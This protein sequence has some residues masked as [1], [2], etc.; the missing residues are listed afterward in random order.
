MIEEVRGNLFDCGAAA[1]V[2]PCSLD[3]I[4]GSGLSLHFRKRFPEMYWAHRAWQ[5]PG[6]PAGF[7]QEGD[8]HVWRAAQTSRHQPVVLSIPVRHTHDGEPDLNLLHLGLRTLG[9][10]LQKQELR[11]PSIAIPRLGSGSL[12]PLPWSQV[13]PLILQTVGDLPGR[14]LLWVDWPPTRKARSV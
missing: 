2:N 14:R 1:L 4:M 7:R 6:N 12:K 10:L 13:R 8:I 5:D 3:G 9:E 11:V